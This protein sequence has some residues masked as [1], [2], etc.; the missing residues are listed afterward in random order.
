MHLAYGT[1]DDAGRQ[2]TQAYEDHCPNKE[3]PRC[4]M[5]QPPSCLGRQLKGL[6]IPHDHI[7]GH[8]FVQ[9]KEVTTLTEGGTNFLTSYTVIFTA[10][11]VLTA[12]RVIASEIIAEVNVLVLDNHRITIDEI[13]RLLGISVE[14]YEFLSQIV[15]GDKTW[16][17][18]F[19]LKSKHQS[20]Q[21]KR[22][23]STSSKKPMDEDTSSGKVMLSFFC[24]QKAR[25]LSSFWNREPPSMS[26]AIK[27]LLRTL[28]EP[29]S[30]NAQNERRPPLKKSSVLIQLENGEREG[31]IL[32][33]L[34]A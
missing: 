14:E 7:K 4:Q 3:I 27:P 24:Y 30:R 32:D 10:I 8:T 2:A 1:V 17:H 26:S 34:M 31:Q 19:Q 20:K 18:H 6:K 25:C 11:V 13:H 5:S 29:S 21:R 12:H 22:A 33:G 28:N 23:T 9:Q 16:D 15:T